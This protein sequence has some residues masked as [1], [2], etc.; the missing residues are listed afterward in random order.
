M[1]LSVVLLASAVFLSACAQSEPTPPPTTPPVEEPY[2]SLPLLELDADSEL[3]VLG[4]HMGWGT[5]WNGEWNKNTNGPKLQRFDATGNPN[6][7]VAVFRNNETESF[8]GI[9]TF[10][11]PA[12][13]GTVSGTTSEGYEFEITRSNETLIYTLTGQYIVALTA[14][15]NPSR[16]AGGGF[17]TGSVPAIGDLP[18]SGIASYSGD[19]IGYST[20]AG[21]VIGDFEMTADFAGGTIAG[22]ITN[23]ETKSLDSINNLTLDATITNDEGYYEGIVTVGLVTGGA[24]DFS[25]NTIGAVEGG[26]YGPNAEETGGVIRV[27]DGQNILTGSF[28]GN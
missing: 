26:F 28:G 8:Y 15:A 4:N 19:F 14:G 11:M 9:G 24:G 5:R 13:G 3:Y 7:Y 20:V 21:E 12:D 16:Y 18:G 1:R 23:I 10:I 25:F 2:E 17:V 6:E 27:S 22:S